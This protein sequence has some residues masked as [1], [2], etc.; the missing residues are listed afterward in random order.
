HAVGLMGRIGAVIKPVLQGAV[1][2]LARGFEDP[3]VDAEQP[4]VITAA[5]AGLAE[6]PELER[7]AA[8]RTMQLEEAH[9]AALVAERDQIL[10][11]HPD[12]QRDVREVVGK[13]DRLPETA[14]IFA[15]RSARA[16]MRQC[17]VLVG[18]LAMKIAAVAG[19]QKPGPG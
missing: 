1:A 6:K 7:G 11:Q 14:Q 8:M 17:R 2:R 4:A 13:A 5:D 12:P 3:A 18:H 15:A 19:L 10:A 16:D 9:G